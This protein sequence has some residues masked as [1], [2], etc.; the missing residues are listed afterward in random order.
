MAL[1]LL[2]DP[3]ALELLL[4]APTEHSGWMVGEALHVMATYGATLPGRAVAD[5]LEPF[6][7]KGEDPASIIG[8]D[9]WHGI[10]KGLAVLLASD[11]P[12]LAIDRMRRLP[13]TR[14]E[15]TDARQLFAILAGCPK[16]EAGAYL[17]ELS[18]TLPATARSWPDLIEAL[19]S[20]EDPACRARLLEMAV[21]PAPG[22]AQAH[23]NS[24]RRE[25]VR[26]AKSDPGFAAALHLQL[27]SMDTAAR[28]LFIHTM[29]ELESEAAMLALLDLADLRP[30]AEI[31]EHMVRGVTLSQVPAGYSG[32]YHLVPRAVNGVRHKLATLL[33]S[34]TREHREIAVRL[35]AAIQKQ[36]IEYGQPMDEFLHPDA[37]LIPQL[38]GPWCLKE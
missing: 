2:N 13:A 10:A 37:A 11:T 1:A 7:A 28:T 17:V 36:R 18:R 9:P 32:T 23:G 33:V 16:P 21:T 25:F 3:R 22:T 12:S 24:L 20:R 14:R 8:H 4:A 35:L 30:V 26:A 34:E 15:D 27:Q 5:A 29:S 19:G 31:L 38:G 6:F